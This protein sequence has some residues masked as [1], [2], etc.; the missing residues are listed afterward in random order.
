MHVFPNE[1]VFFSYII[2]LQKSMSYF[3]D[4]QESVNKIFE[5]GD[6]ILMEFSTFGD[7]F[8]S[9]VTDVGADGRL[10]VYAPIPPLVVERLKTDRYA[11][12]R[13]A[14]EGEL[15]GFDTRVLNDVETA[16]SIIELEKPV[17]MYE[18]EERFEI[19]CPCCFPATV[20]E[21]DRSIQAVV[22]DMSNSCSRVRFL[23]GDLFPFAE[24]GDNDVRL[25]FYPF[26]MSE[27]Y[28]VGCS[29]RNTFMKDG[30]R[31]VVLEYKSNED[32]ACE[33]IAHFV[34]AQLFCGI[35]RM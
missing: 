12:V 1:N 19:R 28:S 21:G 27:G 2:D 11:R 24:E 20:V 34:E 23:N 35:P 3:E 30:S 17:A 26:D 18:A 14:Y 15:H 8:L 31:Y 5:P 10:Y 33:K 6:K 7:R 9:V 16:G 13:F 4:M 32:E 29:V 22:E 25:T